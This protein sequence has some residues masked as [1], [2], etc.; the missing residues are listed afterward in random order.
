MSVNLTV[1]FATHIFDGVIS[2]GKNMI[3]S[4][5]RVGS[6]KIQLQSPVIW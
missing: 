2:N 3:D 1:L 5:Y 4:I 6:Q